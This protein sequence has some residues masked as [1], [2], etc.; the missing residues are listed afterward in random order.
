MEIYKYFKL[1]V[2]TLV[3]NLFIESIYTLN[4]KPTFF[5]I[6]TLSNTYDL[7]HT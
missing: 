7:K 5:E 2:S 4:F 3:Y 1:Q 6:F